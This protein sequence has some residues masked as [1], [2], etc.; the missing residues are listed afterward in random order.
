MKGMILAAGLGT[1]LQPFTNQ[2]PKALFPFDGKPLLFH[3]IQ[4]LISAGIH[5]ILINVHHY[6]DQVT[7]YL[8]INQNFNC[9][10]AISDEQEELLETGG[11]LKKASWFFDN[12]DPFLV[13]NVDI[14][15]DLDLNLLTAKHRDSDALATLAVRDRPTSRYFLFNDRMQLCGW[16]NRKTGEISW[17]RNE[18]ETMTGFSNLA[19]SGIQVIEPGIFSLITEQGKFSLTRLYLRLAAEHCIAGFPESGNLWLDLG[20][21]PA[22]RTQ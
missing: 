21:F 8:R 1:R 13:R 4:H 10:I 12:H 9:E 19:F 16:E 3:A 20:S 11:G 17:C 18:Y 7:E 6:A 14:I 5:E 15:S 2:H 22:G